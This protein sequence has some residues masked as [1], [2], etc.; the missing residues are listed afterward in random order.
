MQINELAKR[1]GLGI[2]V[3][4]R[5]ASLEI[6]RAH[7][8]DRM[9]DLLNEVSDEVLLITNLANSG[10]RRLVELLDAPA[11]CLLNGTTP[12][13]ELQQVAEAHGSALLVSP[14][15]MFETCGRVY[16]ALRE[17]EAID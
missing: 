11:L 6:A 9:S 17:R 2:L 14:W 8:S 12:D 4:G 15:G 7:A 10:V 16:A 5:S 1:S 3:P 13:S